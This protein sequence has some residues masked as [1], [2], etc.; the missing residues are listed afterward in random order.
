MT[1]ACPITA[2]ASQDISQ[3][4]LGRLLN[5]ASPISEA[6]IANSVLKSHFPK[7]AQP[8]L[9]RQGAKLTGKQAALSSPPFL[10]PVPKV[11]G[12][13]SERAW[14]DLELLR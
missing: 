4:R 14:N 10:Q 8:T 1:M 3:L 5:H 12:L 7:R 11:G 6:K 2:I 9:R 13:G